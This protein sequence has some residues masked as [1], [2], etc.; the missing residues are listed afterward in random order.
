[1]DQMIR[2]LLI[3]ISCLGL[4]LKAL[5]YFEY[6]VQPGDTLSEL[7]LSLDVSL[8]DIYLANQ[9]I[10]F[11]PNDIKVGQ[12][13]LVPDYENTFKW[14]P[15]G[16]SLFTTFIYQD[17]GEGNYLTDYLD[18]YDSYDDFYNYCYDE[19][20][21]Q[22]LLAL[23]FDESF[24]LISN[25]ITYQNALVPA[26]G[27]S[28]DA[29]TLYCKYA[30]K[31]VESY[32]VGIDEVCNFSKEEILQ[33][34][35][36]SSMQ[37]LLLYY[38]KYLEFEQIKNLNFKLLPQ[39]IRVEFL[40]KL[41]ADAISV[42]DDDLP[43]LLNES[44]LNMMNLFIAKPS[45]FSNLYEL[46]NLMFYLLNYDDFKKTHEL[47]IRFL[48]FACNGCD[49]YDLQEVILNNGYNNISTLMLAT[50]FD[51]TILNWTAS[52]SNYFDREDVSFY[53]LRESQIE[54]YKRLISLWQDKDEVYSY[55][56]EKT[57]ETLSQTYSDAAT[58]SASRG[59]CEYAARMIDSAFAL[60]DGNEPLTD[61]FREPIEVASCFL[62]NK[63]L[64]DALPYLKLALQ[65][66]SNIE[67]DSDLGVIKFIAEKLVNGNSTPYVKEAYQK[68]LELDTS[69]VLEKKTL[70]VA[71]NLIFILEKEQKTGSIDFIKI[72]NKLKS[73]KAS[74]ALLNARINQKNTS[75]ES[76]KTKLEQVS[77]SISTLEKNIASIDQDKR[78]ELIEFYE[79]KTSIINEIFEQSEK[80][81]SLYSN[82]FENDNELIKQLDENSKVITYFTFEDSAWSVIYQMNT[83]SL[84]DLDYTAGELWANIFAL[85]ESID[86]DQKFSFEDSFRLY[87]KLFGKLEDEF[88][89]GDEIFIYDSKEVNI[90]LSI[91]IRS[92]PSSQNYDKALIE[93]DWLIRDYSFAYLY[94]F[95]K[96]SRQI[97]YQEKFL[98]L[99]N[100]TS[101]DWAELPALKSSEREIQNLALS[102]NA[103]RENVLLADG[104]SKENL[105]KKLSKNYERIVI[106]THAV[107]KG[108]RGYIN[109][110]AL[111]LP[112]NKKDF[113]LTSS[114]IAQ[115]EFSSE[116]VVL[117]ACSGINEDFQD[118]YKS[119]LVAGAESVIHANWQLESRFATEFTDE[120]FKELWINDG[121]SKHE[122]IR[123]VAL[124]YLSD[125]SNP[126]YANPL[127]WG[128][129]SIGYSEL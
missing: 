115:S 88:N 35:Y 8:E 52:V 79:L 125:Y 6:E 111:V 57:V 29:Q 74:S 128:N 58:Y 76:L 16:Q 11:N 68:I 65:A 98:G 87:E 55:F 15:W 36:D 13:I 7:A 91:L 104:A 1:M 27:Y 51:K 49:Q 61:N 9:N 64:N 26:S 83:V 44:Y 60:Y 118:L 53:E 105:M 108:W 86:S 17:V 99:A 23:A 120:L 20:K 85:E 97:Q 42:G 113:F 21:L 90:P 30:L 33:S 32:L 46:T 112:S 106:A 66:S 69:S 129:F 102:S 3:S 70:E 39:E 5:E 47:F 24:E 22:E 56:R 127:F 40:S 18:Y 78:N 117:S 101:Y 50:T 116:M 67:E 95:K 77:A 81:N 19:K 73:L 2:V 126:I 14:C 100:S 71:L 121:I 48:N 25:D 109:E 93:A 122:A 96:D 84:H 10:G 38:F 28:T 43:Y 103:K 89:Y 34:N 12:R 110:A 82:Y 94:P 54:N 119:F 63:N 114:E 92:V 123:N 124:K 31:G 80:L 72:K 45:H 59:R 62:K 75:L 4:P 107:P 37:K 41:V